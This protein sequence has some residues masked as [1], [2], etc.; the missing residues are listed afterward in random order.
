MAL[1]PIGGV[2]DVSGHIG[3]MCLNDKMVGIRTGVVT[4]QVADFVI[5]SLDLL[6][7]VD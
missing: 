4:T 2:A 7:R 1:A 3:L 5:E 6:T